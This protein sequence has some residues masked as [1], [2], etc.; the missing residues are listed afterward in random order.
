M[1]PET[2]TFIE[3]LTQHARSLGLEVLVEIHSH[4]Q[5]QI[6]IARQVDRVY[7]FALPALILL[8]ALRELTARH[9]GER[10]PQCR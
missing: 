4:Y 6:E 1:I 2:F 10:T 3:E 5:K 8:L 9:G 7:D